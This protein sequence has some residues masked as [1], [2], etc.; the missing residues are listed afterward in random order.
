MAIGLMVKAPFL[1]THEGTKPQRLSRL[2]GH[3]IGVARV[4]EELPK[5]CSSADHF[6]DGRLDAEGHREVAPEL[7]VDLDRDADAG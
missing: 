5:T 1:P 6:Q 7:A 2:L 4:G 3:R